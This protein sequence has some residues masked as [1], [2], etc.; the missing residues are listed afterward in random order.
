MAIYIAPHGEIKWNGG[1]GG[2]YDIHTTDGFI[3]DP[4]PTYT[5]GDI[6]VFK[7]NTAS[8]TLDGTAATFGNSSSA[9]R[10]SSAQ[11]RFRFISTNTTSY[12]AVSGDEL[13]PVA[14][15]IATVGSVGTVGIY[16]LQNAIDFVLGTYSA[17]D[18]ITIGTQTSIECTFDPNGLDPYAIEFTSS[19][20]DKATVSYDSETNELTITPIVDGTATLTGTLTLE[21]GTT[22]VVYTYTI[23]VDIPVPQDKM[24]GYNAI[25]FLKREIAA[26]RPTLTSELT[27]DGSDGTSTYVESDDLTTTLSGY[28]EKLTAGNRISIDSSNVIAFDGMTILKYGTSTWQ[29]FIDAYKANSIVYCRA[30]SN[31]N[32]ASGAQTRLAFMAYVNDETNPANV[33][34]QYYR[35]VSSHSESQQTDQVFVYKLTNASGGTWSVTTREAGTKIVA[36]TG[37]TSSYSNGVLTISLA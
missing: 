36:G 8:G 4:A 21:D 3:I 28:Q 7:T 2:A 18:T 35:S 22:T 13:G 27:N 11:S 17:G 20:T 33:E 19:D 29:D 30:S 37:L 15:K 25:G 34:F 6:L 9:S 26:S 10:F 23:N 31:S 1:G 32:P 12:T 24:L 16:A 5:V 14:V